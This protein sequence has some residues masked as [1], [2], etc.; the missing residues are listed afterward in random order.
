MEGDQ[1]SYQ[2]KIKTYITPDFVKVKTADGSLK[3]LDGNHEI[4]NEMDK[5]LAE[6]GAKL[7]KELK[8]NRY[9]FFMTTYLINTLI[10]KD[11]LSIA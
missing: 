10:W 6:M 11:L 7:A 5:Q 4:T 9:Y 3:K 2:P 1:N 8:K